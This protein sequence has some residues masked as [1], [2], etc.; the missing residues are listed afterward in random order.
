MFSVTSECI[1]TDNTISSW[2]CY[3]W[4]LRRISPHLTLWDRDKMAAIF[5]TT[6]PRTFTWMKMYEFRL[7]FHWSLFLR[8]HITIFPYWLRYWFDVEQAKSHYVNQ[9]RPSLLTHICDTR[10]SELSSIR[11]LV[12]A[13]WHIFVW[14]KL[15]YHWSAPSRYLHQYWF[16]VN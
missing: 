13:E 15:G 8:V 4:L 1:L 5:Q 9:W 14:V 2:D 7:R 3:Q 16:I 6:F 12:E 10:L 11:Y